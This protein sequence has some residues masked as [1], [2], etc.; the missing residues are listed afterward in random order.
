MQPNSGAVH[1]LITIAS[2]YYGMT[3]STLQNGLQHPWWECLNTVRAT[4]IYVHSR[5]F[6]NNLHHIVI[7]IYLKRSYNILEIR[8]HHQLILCSIESMANSTHKYPKYNL[9]C[10]GFII[11]NL[12]Y[13]NGHTDS[14]LLWTILGAY[15]FLIYII[16][17]FFFT[18]SRNI[19]NIPFGLLL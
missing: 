14:S 1:I 3:Q 19:W 9:Y 4:Y 6:M 12:I 11:K 17:V 10:N 13:W 7:E 18:E 2:S 16:I 8:S 5:H 15:I